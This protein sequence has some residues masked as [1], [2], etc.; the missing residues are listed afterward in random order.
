[1]IRSWLI[2]KTDFDDEELNKRFEQQDWDFFIKNKIKIWSLNEKA[3][4]YYEKDEE[5]IKQFVE[6]LKEAVADES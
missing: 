5:K 3:V 4:F 1:M 2:N 6:K